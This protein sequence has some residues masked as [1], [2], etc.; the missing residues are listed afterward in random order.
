M[1]TISI[2]TLFLLNIQTVFSQNFWPAQIKL[3]CYEDEFILAIDSKKNVYLIFQKTRD[4][5]TGMV[6][7]DTFSFPSDYNY[8]V[9]YDSTGKVQWAKKLNRYV[10][11][12][13]LV[14][15]SSKNLL[16]DKEDNILVCF[17]FIQPFLLDT[18][19]IRSKGQN[20]IMLAKFNTDGNLLWYQQIGTNKNEN[21]YGM[22]MDDSGN[23]AISGMF[24]G[25]VKFDTMS[26]VCQ[27]TY[28]AFVAQFNKNR[29]CIWA[30]RMGGNNNTTYIA[31]GGLSY[32]N[33]EV[34][35][36]LSF[37]NQN[38]LYFILRPCTLCAG[39]AIDTFQLPPDQNYF[40]KI[41]TTGT[42]IW[43]KELKRRTGTNTYS[44]PYFDLILANKEN[45][46]CQGVTY[47]DIVYVG[48]VELVFT[49]MPWDSRR[50]TATF[51]SNMV[52]VL[53]AKSTI[54][55][56]FD[57]CVPDR[58]EF[59]KTGG[60][61]CNNWDNSIEHY[62]ANGNLI[63][64]L[65]FSQDSIPAVNCFAVAGNDSLFLGGLFRGSFTYNNK[66]L[67]STDNSYDAFVLFYTP[68]LTGLDSPPSL[69]SQL[70]IFNC[71]PNPSNSIFNIS[72]PQT[73]QHLE[74]QVINLTGTI[75][76]KNNTEGNKTTIDLSKLPQGIY[77]IMV[78][79][80]SQ[81]LVIQ[82]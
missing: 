40:I 46:F 50:I 24:S 73:T 61:Y 8:L 65:N 6:K 48:N 69:N 37:D 38:N 14:G 76:Y 21:L 35:A 10:F 75:V 62:D 9:K 34:S 55:F 28:D 26:L 7:I 78:N 51:D 18:F 12:Q 4:I 36:S 42:I 53:W 57:C 5:D 32:S 80:I 3:S 72:A 11:T 2:I 63:R 22:A 81:R 15:E 25:T 1:K 66:T 67:M 70:S 16:V 41:D 27:G 45:F 74:I 23:I 68:T 30:K 43:I 47:K 52:D 77:N 39:I 20:D 19:S 58:F 13:N 56:G 33:T 17:N 59:D 71:Y 54:P 64:K 60:F 79:N 49:G 82:R 31:N 44:D 29:Q